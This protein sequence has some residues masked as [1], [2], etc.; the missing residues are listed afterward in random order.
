MIKKECGNME[1]KGREIRKRGLFQSSRSVVAGGICA[2]IT[3]VASAYFFY[4]SISH[5]YNAE[6]ISYG[7]RSVLIISNDL[8]S[9]LFMSFFLGTLAVI[10]IGIIYLITGSLAA[11]KDLRGGEFAEVV[12]SR[13]TEF[14]TEYIAV[15]EEVSKCIQC[16]SK[17]IS[18]ARFCNACGIEQRTVIV[19]PE[20]CTGCGTRFKSADTKFCSNCGEK[21][22]HANE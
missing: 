14:S 20:R 2:L 8:V 10:V 5:I 17:M 7:G 4:I 9:W 15:L 11:Y 19:T 16:G 3:G 18:G 21:N 13:R 12:I 22:D 6:L 1:I